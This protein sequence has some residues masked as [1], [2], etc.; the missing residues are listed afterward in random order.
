MEKKYVLNPKAILFIS[1]NSNPF[2]TGGTKITDSKMCLKLNENNKMLFPKEN[3][4]FILSFSNPTN[5]EESTKKEGVLSGPRYDELKNLFEELRTH[6][7]I[8]T[9]DGKYI[10]DED[11]EEYRDLVD[12]H[13]EMLT[14][15]VRL[16]G[17]RDVLAELCKKKNFDLA[18]DI[19]VGTGVLALMAEKEKNIKKV[20]AVERKK[21][22]ELAKKIADD[23]SS[24]VEFIEDESYNVVLKEKA[25]LL[26]TETFGSDV[27]CENIV[28][29]MKHAKENLLK[30][31]ATIIPSQASYC[32]KIINVKKQDYYKEQVKNI[33]K[34]DFERVFNE[35]SFKQRKFV[36][37]RL[38]NNEYEVVSDEIELIKLDFYSDLK[39]LY[40]STVEYTVT[41]PGGNAVC[42]YLNLFSEDKVF[43]TSLRDEPNTWTKLLFEFPEGFEFKA[44][45]KLK[46]EFS[47]NSEEKKTITKI[48]VNGSQFS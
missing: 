10:D 22:I 29:I 25:D 14:D 30:P 31:N 2:V 8:L 33:T 4:N 5:F 6:E 16:K 39:D 32:A 20:V 36:F 11:K 15:T 12:A 23:N 3:L 46:I 42:F 28:E 21:I 34:L 44:K 40:E 19:G 41:K 26:I 45:D 47:R 35:A 43:L 7:F 17:Y 38:G 18:L 13:Y 1:R 27:F 9:S 48:F 24:K 37:I